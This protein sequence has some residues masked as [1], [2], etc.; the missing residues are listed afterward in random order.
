[1]SLKASKKSNKMQFLASHETVN[2]KNSY[3]T[4]EQT[5]HPFMKPQSVDKIRVSR[6]H[7]EPSTTKAMSAEGLEAVQLY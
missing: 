2:I 7:R 1:M 3:Q 4:D 6:E 5:V